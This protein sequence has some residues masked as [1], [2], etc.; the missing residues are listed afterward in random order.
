MM[1]RTKS[2]VVYL[3]CVTMRLFTNKPVI[4]QQIMQKT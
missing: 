4:K 3:G 2:V 1:Y